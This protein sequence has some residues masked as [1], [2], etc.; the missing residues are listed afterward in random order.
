[1]AEDNLDQRRSSREQQLDWEANQSRIAQQ[2]ADILRNA[3]SI[4]QL[5]GPVLSMQAVCFR[6]IAD[7]VEQ[8]ARSFDQAGQ[9]Q[10]GQR[11]QQN[12]QR[13]SQQRYSG[14]QVG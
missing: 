8:M 14:Q 9:Q 2:T 6:A 5:L 10:H 1:M 11:G 3:G 7:G 12:S 13:D 4:N